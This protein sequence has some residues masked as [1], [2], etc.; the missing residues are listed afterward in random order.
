MD[1]NYK[2][3]QITK[4]IIKDANDIYKNF[5]HELSVERS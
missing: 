1:D 3:K 5:K 2:N 4:E